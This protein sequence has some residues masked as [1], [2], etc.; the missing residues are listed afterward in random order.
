VFV[1]IIGGIAA[2]WSFMDITYNQEY[3]IGYI[4]FKEKQGHSVETICLSDDLN[5]DMAADGSIYGIELLNANEQLGAEGAFLHFLN[6][7][8]NKSQEISL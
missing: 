1:N 4:R 8:T 5:V 3:N 2:C 6:A 7:K